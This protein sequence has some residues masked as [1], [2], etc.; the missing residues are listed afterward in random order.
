M[1]RTAII[2]GLFLASTFI[3][4]VKASDIIPAPTMQVKTS[5]E[6]LIP[7]VLTYD[8]G[9]F[10]GDAAAVIA[11]VASMPA[12]AQSSDKAALRIV[13]DTTLGDEAYSMSVTPT[14]IVIKASTPKGLFYGMQTLAQLCYGS[15]AIPAV[16]IEDAPRFGWRGFMLDEGRHIFGKDEIKKV[17]DMMALYKLNRFHWHL[18]EDQGWRFEVPGYPKLT[19][20]G[21]YRPS[22]SLGWREMLPDTI[23]YGGFYTDDDIREIVSYAAERYID[24]VP[25]ID[26]PGHSQAA[27]AAY[28]EFLACDPDSTHEVWTWQGVSPDVINVAN[29]RAVQ[30]AKDVLT[31]VTSLFPYEYLH[32]GGDECPTIKWKNNDACKTRLSELGS[33]NFRDLQLDFYRQLNSHL[34]SVSPRKLIFWNEVLHGNTEML[35]DADMTIMAWVGANQA[36]LDAAS[37]GL[38]TILSPQIPYYINRKQSPDP[39]EPMS[40]GQGT[41][42]VEKVYAYVP[43]AD[44]PDSLANHY[45]GV[46]AN[47]WSEYVETPEVLE[48]LMMPRLAAVAEA[49]WT[50]Q[51][52]RSYADFKRRMSTHL[53]L[54]ENRDWKYAT[55]MFD[56]I[57][58]NG[59]GN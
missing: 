38:N 13:K 6:F 15:T 34:D 29:P 26:I 37:R 48:Y 51:D 58:D 59:Q 36:A 18:T 53:P 46:Q 39:N 27:I 40:Q 54:L 33:E 1:K 44:V 10:N 30:F 42:T 41:E 57:A 4:N 28:P 47:F 52:G 56:D 22:T 17:L 31:H 7:E 16:E 55:H 19:E 3:Q 12:T 8:S 9:D 25:E 43:M 45:L 14:G 49:A 20:V 23:P 11:A 21:A 50:P 5:G 24:I 32:L 35:S 2:A